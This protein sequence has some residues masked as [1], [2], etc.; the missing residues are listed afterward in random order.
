MNL[1]TTGKIAEHLNVDCDVVSYALR[2]LRIN[3]T[4]CAGHVRVFPESAVPA[5]REFIAS[6]KIGHANTTR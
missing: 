1:L 5:V 4:G 6:R 2:K 3:P